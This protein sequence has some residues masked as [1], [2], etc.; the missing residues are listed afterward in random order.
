MRPTA[1]KDRFPHPKKSL[2]TA[3]LCRCSGSFCANFLNVFAA[4]DDCDRNDLASTCIHF[5]M[6]SSGTHHQ[7]SSRDA[8]IGVK[9]NGR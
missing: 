8:D 7:R 4:L 6:Q 3:T 1:T 2:P 9:K 5:D